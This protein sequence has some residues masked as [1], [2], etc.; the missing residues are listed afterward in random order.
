MCA[1]GGKLV[2]GSFAGRI[3]G[4]PAPR[5]VEFLM[6]FLSMIGILAIFC[7]MVWCFEHFDSKFSKHYGTPPRQWNEDD[8]EFM[9]HVERQAHNGFDL[10]D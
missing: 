10:E 9:A 5:E 3:L 6:L 7:G 2:P 8:P 4:L 1:T